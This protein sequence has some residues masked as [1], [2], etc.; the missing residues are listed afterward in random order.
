MK[1]F[2]NKNWKTILLVVLVASFALLVMFN[3]DKG[4]KESSEQVVAW[5][6][7]TSQEEPV[8]TVLASSTCGY[9]AQYEP[10]IEALAEENDFKLYWFE[11]D[12]LNDTDTQ[13]LIST[14]EL[15]EFDGSVPYTFITEDNQ[16]V[17][18]TIGAMDK[19]NTELL[20][21]NNGVIKE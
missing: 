19:A 13:T 4:V 7:D 11:L 5:S 21:K 10:V 14:Y 9:C 12:Q 2:F 1:K 6:T 3:E 18:H 16:F 17:T 8:V 15:E 20:L